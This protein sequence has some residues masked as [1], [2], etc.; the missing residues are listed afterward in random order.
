MKRIDPEALAR[1]LRSWFLL[2]AKIRLIEVTRSSRAY[3]T[4]G[5]RDGGGPAKEMSRYIADSAGRS[6]AW[7]L[8]NARR[9]A[10]PWA[11]ESERTGIWTCK[12]RGQLAPG[13]TA[14]SVAP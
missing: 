6:G 3:L 2:G 7:L 11:L 9:C 1:D 4:E 10:R 14:I 8:A 13:S 5:K 12:S